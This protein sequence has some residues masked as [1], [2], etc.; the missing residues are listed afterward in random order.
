MIFVK[1]NIFGYERNVPVTPQEI[2]SAGVTTRMIAFVGQRIVD[3]FERR[4]D[5][6]SRRILTR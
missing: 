3:A 1:V 6:S 5:Q 4:S 2:R